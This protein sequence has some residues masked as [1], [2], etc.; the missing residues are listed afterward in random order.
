MRTAPV[1]T[2]ELRRRLR[3]AL[4]AFKRAGGRGVELADEIDGV[5]LELRSRA[6]RKGW[7][8]RMRRIGRRGFERH[9]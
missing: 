2:S 1:K 5:R 3:E 8:K 7:K 9:R 4:C 6:A